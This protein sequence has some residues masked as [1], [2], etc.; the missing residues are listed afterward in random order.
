MKNNF[1]LKLSSKITIPTLFV[2]AFIII[3]FS[4]LGREFVKN[5]YKKHTTKVMQTK[6]QNFNSNLDKL[7]NQALYIASFCAEI[8]FVKY[9]YSKLIETNDLYR[10]SFLLENNFK[11]ITKSIKK[12]TKIDAK[13]HFHTKD[14]KSFI[15]LWNKKRGDDLTGFRSMINRII[16]NHHA[17]SGAEIGRSGVQ[18]RGLAPIFSMSKKKYLGS[19]E[20]LLPLIEVLR[21]SKTDE[22][23]DFALFLDKRKVE[24]SINSKLKKKRKD[25]FGQFSFITRTSKNFK[26]QYIDSTFLNLVL[27]KD[28]FMIEKNNYKIAGMPLK[29]FENNKIGVIIFQLDIGDN[30]KDLAKLNKEQIISMFISLFVSAIFLIIL[31][32]FLIKKPLSKI[33]QKIKIISLRKETNE[34]AIKTHDEISEISKSINVLIKG[35]ISSSDF[36]KEIEKG[37]FNAQFKPLCEDDIL[38]NALIEMSNSLAKAKE[39]EIKRKIEDKQRHWTSEGIAQFS[40]ILRQNTDDIK[41]LSTLIISHFVE[42]LNVNQVSLYFYKKEKNIEYLEPIASYAHE[43]ENFLN[44]RYELG[45]NLVGT[46]AKNKETIFLKKAPKDYLKISSGLGESENCNLLLVPLQTNEKVLGVV[47]LASLQEIHDYQID[48]VEIVAES[49]A[50]TLS[51]SFMNSNRNVLFE[52]FKKQSEQMKL[53]EKMME[54]SLEDILLSRQK[55]TEIFEHELLQVLHQI[56]KDFFVTEFDKNGLLLNMSKSYE[57]LLGIKKENFRR[58]NYIEISELEVEET[59]KT[60][61]SIEQ[62]NL[63]R[64]LFKTTVKGKDVW[65][66]E[67]YFPL[68]KNKKFYKLFIIAY[69]VT[70]FQEKIEILNL[71]IKMLKTQKN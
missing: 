26:A 3:A 57:D 37:N 17:V 61:N 33:N 48:F 8:P 39:I 56:D 21:S 47:E 19:V 23:E 53:Q 34:L 55:N 49:I 60:W 66:K 30:K 46:C 1:H 16:L 64:K 35:Q 38:G 62:G 71:K 11:N 69:D 63:I 12:N 4:Y 45:E 67:I 25:K 28:F 24:K 68:M 15:R 6:L 41:K 22:T 13:I 52:K 43:K 50:S 14:G 2:V 42:F 54:E 5:N 36:A 51:I 59:T 10:S 70:V 65:L 32:V 40:E 27:K 31:I 20:V 58:K 44:E 7:A 9:A 29:D 18:I